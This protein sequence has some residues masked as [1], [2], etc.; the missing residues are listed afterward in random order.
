MGIQNVSNIPLDVWFVM[1]ERAESNSD[2]RCSISSELGKREMLV[3]WMP[4]SLPSCLFVSRPNEPV[5]VT[6]EAMQILHCLGIACPQ[7]TLPQSNPVPD[8]DISANPYHYAAFSVSPVD[9]IAAYELPFFEGNVVKYV[10]RA[11]YKNG[12]GDLLKA[13]WYLL[14][15]LGLKKDEIEVMVKQVESR[16]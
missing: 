3:T 4:S 1:A 9:L 12:R 5:E 8:T 11:R 7:P 10:T 14:W 2:M 16:P 13:L 15:C 6:H